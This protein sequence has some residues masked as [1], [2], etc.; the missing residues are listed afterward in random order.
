MFPVSFGGQ[1]RI[2][3][4]HR[5]RI[6]RYRFLLGAGRIKKEESID[7]SA[8]IKILK[9]TGTGGKGD[10]IAVLFAS[11]RDYLQRRKTLKEALAYS[12]FP[13]EKRPSSSIF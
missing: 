5:Y 2:Y 13:P 10:G 6:I 7:P 4:P 11:T 9:K 1:R 3:F 12:E 8:G